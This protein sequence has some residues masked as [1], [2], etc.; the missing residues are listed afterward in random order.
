[1]HNATLSWKPTGGLSERF[2]PQTYVIPIVLVALWFVVSPYLVSNGI[3]RYSFAL[4]GV[5]LGV[6]TIDLIQRRQRPTI[7]ILPWLMAAGLVGDLRSG[8]FD[9]GVLKYGFDILVT[10]V[11]TIAI[12]SIYLISLNRLTRILRTLVVFTTVTVSMTGFYQ[13]YQGRLIGD[14]SATLDSGVEL[15]IQMGKLCGLLYPSANQAGVALLLALGILLGNLLTRSTA[16]DVLFFAVNTVALALTYSRGAY[17]GFAV[18]LALALFLAVSRRPGIQR[19]SKGATAAGVMAILGLAVAFSL[20]EGETNRDRLSNPGTLFARL[21]LYAGAVRSQGNT[22]MGRGFGEDLAE[23]SQAV[24]GSYI[25]PHNFFL[26]WTV[27]FGW[28]PSIALLAMLGVQLKRLGMY[29]YQ[30]VSDARHMGIC[31]GT[32][33]AL[34]GVVVASIAIVDSPFFVLL[35]STLAAAY[36]GQRREA[37]CEG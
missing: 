30:G 12:L 25:S 2:S 32:T 35:A 23:A 8:G 11:G 14:F 17:F 37:R 18:M 6:C 22:L 31:L 10:N 20:V 36:I 24:T 3:M 15:S 34:T 29:S 28:V 16:L 1:M 5:L 19:I 27:R 33:L 26:G 9:D 4:R 21:D 7:G 13:L